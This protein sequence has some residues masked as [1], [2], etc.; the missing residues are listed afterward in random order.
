MTAE[1]G[2]ILVVDDS[3]VNR[4][5]LVR[6]L[7]TQGHTVE[8]TEDGRQALAMLARQP[9]DVVLLDILMPELDGYQTLALIKKWSKVEQSR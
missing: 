7:T 6:G 8:T 4:M 2:R 3:K 9:F 5:V 1:G